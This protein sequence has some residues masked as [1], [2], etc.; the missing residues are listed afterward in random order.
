LRAAVIGLG[1]VWPE[2]VSAYEELAEGTAQPVHRLNQKSGNRLQSIRGK[3][4]GQKQEDEPAVRSGCKEKPDTQKCCYDRSH[5]QEIR[6]DIKQ[7]HQH[8]RKDCQ[9]QH[10]GNGKQL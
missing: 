2:A 9:R 10:D 5:C 1:P 3:Q 7:E 8:G 6:T 4:E